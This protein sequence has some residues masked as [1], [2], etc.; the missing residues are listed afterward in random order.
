MTPPTKNDHGV[1]RE[2]PEEDFSRWTWKSTEVEDLYRQIRIDAART[3]M[4]QIAADMMIELEVKDGI[5]FV[6]AWMFEAETLFRLPL[7]AMVEYFIESR[8][9][10]NGGIETSPERETAEIIVAALER[11]LDRLRA[12]LA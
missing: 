12:T 10:S 2:G 1:E 4:A 8:V 11:A 5:A 9:T 7:D 6:C 3:V